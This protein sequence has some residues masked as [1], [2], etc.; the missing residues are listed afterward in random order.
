MLALGVVTDELMKLCRHIV[1]VQA[2]TESFMSAC[3]AGVTHFTM[4]ELEDLCFH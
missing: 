1:R 4:S 2:L 3:I